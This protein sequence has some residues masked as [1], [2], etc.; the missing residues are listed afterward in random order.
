VPADDAR[1]WSWAITDLLADE[2]RRAR[3][4]ALG[5]ERARCF[6][7]G[8]AAEAL[9]A[10]YQALA[11]VLAANGLEGAPASEREAGGRPW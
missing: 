3:M 5:L 11:P 8:R 6:S 7:Y 1:A 10:E 4:S 9:A 2:G